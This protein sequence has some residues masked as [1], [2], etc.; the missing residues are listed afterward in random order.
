MDS[1]S[2]SLLWLDAD[3]A[4]PPVDRAWGEASDAPGLLAAGGGLDM[5]R[6]RS[7]YTQGIFPW[8]SQGQP[9][10]WWSPNP[11]M[12]LKVADFRLHRS[13]KKTL[14]R[15]NQT[16]GC[17]IRFDTVFGTVIRK[18]AQAPREGQNGTWILGAIV[19][20]YCTLHA[21][22]LAHSVETW[23][24]GELV[25][26]LYCVAI[27]QAVFG[28]SMFS[29]RT[30]GSKIALSALVAFCL[31]HGVAQIDCQQNTRHLASLGASPVARADFVASLSQ[32]TQAPALDWQFSPAHW[33]PLLS[34]D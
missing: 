3:D 9:V 25:A 26:G 17:E 18:C 29:E 6:L 21:Q 30:D 22:G 10:L 31:Q 7:A 34:T 4:F 24:D 32:A 19:D 2:T 33:E 12:V 15:F 27:G 16:P 28:E 1:T 11:R 23:V 20:A 5:A 13:L 8:Y 14:R